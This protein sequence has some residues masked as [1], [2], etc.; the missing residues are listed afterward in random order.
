MPRTEEQARRWNGL[1]TEQNDFVARILEDCRSLEEQV[2]EEEQRFQMTRT[3]GDQD[4]EDEMER[5]MRRIKEDREIQEAEEEVATYKAIVAELRHAAAP[6]THFSH[7]PAASDGSECSSSSE[8]RIEG[9]QGSPFVLVLLDGTKA[10]FFRGA[11]GQGFVGGKDVAVR[12]RWE[13]EKDLKEHPVHDEEGEGGH[14][15]ALK[16]TVV[17]FVLVDPQVLLPR[18]QRQRVVSSADT[19]DAFIRGFQTFPEHNVVQ[20]ADGVVGTLADLLLNFGHASN[21]KRVYL[22]GVGYARMCNTTPEL[23]SSNISFYVDVG[24]KMVLINCSE[25]LE[26]HEELHK[27]GWRVVDFKGLFDVDLAKAPS[28]V[29]SQGSAAST[30]SS[31]Q[32]SGTNTLISTRAERYRSFTKPGSKHVFAPSKRILQQDPEICVWHYVSAEGCK[33]APCDRSHKY[34]LTSAGLQALREEVSTVRCKRFRR[35]VG[36]RQGQEAVI[37]RL[38]AAHSSLAQSLQLLDPLRGL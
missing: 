32:S 13:I 11:L 23:G 34:D 16:P 27:S 12:L 36:E 30:A 10:P 5:Q 25:T 17:A 21:L 9:P 7:V 22:G 35:S 20:T 4:P 29:G 33:Q 8:S 6:A 28:F 19:F 31:L 1:S 26:E 14:I 37:A 3:L 18:L 2:E 24:P 38:A 15:S